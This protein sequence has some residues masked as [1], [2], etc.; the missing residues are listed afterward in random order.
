MKKREKKTELFYIISGIQLKSETRR[1]KNFNGT[2]EKSIN[3]EDTKDKISCFI[4]LQRH[5]NR[6][7]E[8]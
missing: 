2:L 3:A 6:K 7:R 1:N 4:W 5:R 8:A